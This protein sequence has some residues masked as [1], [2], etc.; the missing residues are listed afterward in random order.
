[1]N[2]FALLFP[3]A[4][5]LQDQMYSFSTNE[6]TQFCPFCKR[7][8]MLPCFQG[9]CVCFPIPSEGGYRPLNLLMIYWLGDRWKRRA[10]QSLAF[11]R[12]NS[13]MEGSEGGADTVFEEQG[14]C[15]A[16]KHYLFLLITPLK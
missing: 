3:E 1:M 10:L 6:M 11:E 7:R 9:A 12:M 8:T 13:C 16:Q 4:K 14:F 15:A 5:H 2:A